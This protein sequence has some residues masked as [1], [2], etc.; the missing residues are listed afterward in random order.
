MTAASPRGDRVTFEGAAKT[1]RLMRSFDTL[2]AYLTRS[3]PVPAGTVVLTGTG[4]IVTEAAAL[5][6]GDVVSIRVSQIGELVNPV[7]MV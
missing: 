6:A 7:V 1:A 4:I 5:A 3:N 2:V